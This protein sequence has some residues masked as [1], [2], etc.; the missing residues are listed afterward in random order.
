MPR[1]SSVA[2]TT[3]AS[4]VLANPLTGANTSSVPLLTKN[5]GPAAVFVGGDSTVAVANGVLMP[6]MALAA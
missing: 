5:G 6:P 2:V 3:A 1:E 4:L